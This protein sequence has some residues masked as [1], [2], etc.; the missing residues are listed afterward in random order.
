MIKNLIEHI[1]DEN[2]FDD[3]KFAIEPYIQI[4]SAKR[5][6][7]ILQSHQVC[8]YWL[9]NRCQA[10]AQC[11]YRHSRGE[12]TVVCKHWL[13]GLCKKSEDCEYLHVY[14]MTKLPPC[15]FF[16]TFGNPLVFSRC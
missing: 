5:K 10:G 1:C 7:K 16:N 2:E 13:R 11:P 3:H 4:Q 14:D 15:H 9:T 8:Q 6:Q 12:K